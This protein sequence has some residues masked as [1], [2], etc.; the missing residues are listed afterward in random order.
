MRRCMRTLVSLAI[1]LQI[2]GCLVSGS[3]SDRGF[4]SFGA[5][6]TSGAGGGGGGSPALPPYGGTPLIQTAPSGGFFGGSG[7]TIGGSAFGG[8][9]STIGAQQGSIVPTGP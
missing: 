1:C 6:G 8:G 4:A 5:G 3:Y 7:F 2:G 9:F